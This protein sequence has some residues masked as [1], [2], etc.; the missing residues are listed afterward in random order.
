MHSS[1]RVSDRLSN[2]NVISIVT[3]SSVY[4][5][6]SHLYGNA[7]AAYFAFSNALPSVIIE[8]IFTVLLWLNAPY[9][10]LCFVRAIY[11]QVYMYIKH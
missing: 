2:N 9:G 1:A 6:L 4:S 11:H 10:Y 3:V 7:V 8:W 5:N